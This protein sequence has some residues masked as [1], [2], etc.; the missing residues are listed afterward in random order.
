[1]KV[2]EQKRKEENRR[3]RKRTEENGREQ[4]RMEE[5]RGERK[6]EGVMKVREQER[7]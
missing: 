5:N 4:R 6:I 7:K 3:E 1:M 2:R